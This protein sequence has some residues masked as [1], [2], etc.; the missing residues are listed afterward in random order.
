MTD[1]TDT[2]DHIA[3]PA[4]VAR[5]VAIAATATHDGAWL[6]ALLA[7]PLARTAT[8]ADLLTAAALLRR[9]T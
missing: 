6:A 5:L 2:A 9:G 7:D 8:T 4:V 3:D 1:L